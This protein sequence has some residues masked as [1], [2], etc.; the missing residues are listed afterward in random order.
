MSGLYRTELDLSLSVNIETLLFPYRPL[1]Q[2]VHAFC[3]DTCG[4]DVPFFDTPLPEPWLKRGTLQI[5][6]WLYENSARRLCDVDR[7]V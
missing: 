1:M 7:L 5:A 3:I 2:C 6:R 4:V